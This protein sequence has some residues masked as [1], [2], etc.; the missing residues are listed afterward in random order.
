MSIN[1]AEKG[2]LAATLGVTGLF[3]GSMYF[4]KSDVKKH[5]A[6]KVRQ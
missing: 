5:D 4:K 2:F 3:M 1:L 6:F